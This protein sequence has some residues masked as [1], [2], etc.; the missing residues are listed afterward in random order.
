MESGGPAP[1]GG[2]TRVALHRLAIVV[3]I[4]ALAAVVVWAS[5]Q[6][7]PRLPGS[8]GQWSWMVAGI[9]IYGVGTLLRSAR[10]WQIMRRAGASL[11]PADA[12]GLTIVSYGGNNVLPARG[13]DAIRSW[14]GAR[15]GGTT[16]RQVVGSLVA[17]R[18]LDVLLILFLFVVLSYGVLR[19]IETPDES[20]LALGLGLLAGAIVIGAIALVIARRHDRGRRITDFLAPVWTSTRDLR[21]AYG[22]R[23]LALTALIWTAESGTY[24]AGGQAVGLDLDPIG[25]VYVVA[26]ASVFVLVPSGPGYVGTLDAGIVFGLKARD[27]ASG[28]ATVS[29]V[30]MMRFIVLV[31]IT[32]LALVLLMRRYGGLAALR[33]ARES[34]GTA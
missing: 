15:R 4:L 18:V 5:H 24:Y 21:G 33:R 8:A 12:V 23:M 26:V 32:L 25:A 31:P 20:R 1:G 11:S 22:A 30:L 19:G 10:W 3:W 6:E 17:E 16:V 2:T 14:L 13:G 9:G 29:Y 34:G 7:P 28:A 27:A